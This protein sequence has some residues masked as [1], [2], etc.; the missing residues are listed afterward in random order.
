MDLR[1]FPFLFFRQAVVVPCAGE[2]CDPASRISAQEQ[3]RILLDAARRRIHIRN[4]HTDAVQLT[5][6]VVFSVFVLGPRHHF[7]R[8]H[9][10]YA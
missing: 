8:I 4:Q 6:H 3:P 2:C 1:T 10:K 7:R 9:T 5:L